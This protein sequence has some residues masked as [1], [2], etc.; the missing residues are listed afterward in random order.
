MHPHHLSIYRFARLAATLI[1]AGLVTMRAGDIVSAWDTPEAIV[2][3]G[4]PVFLTATMIAA[5]ASHRIS[6]ARLEQ[7]VRAAELRASTAEAEL[8][9][10]RFET[11]EGIRE[12]QAREDEERGWWEDGVGED[13]VPFGKTVVRLDCHRVPQARASHNG[14]LK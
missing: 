10:L 7:D 2:E 13:T 5:L 11:E 14:A 6:V 8:R 9:R 1:A 4:M 3:A 12:Q